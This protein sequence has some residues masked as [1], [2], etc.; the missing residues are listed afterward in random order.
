M[1]F[2]NFKVLGAFALIGAVVATSQVA[3]AQFRFGGR[4][5]PAVSR[6]TRQ[7]PSRSSVRPTR[8]LQRYGIGGTNVPRGQAPPP[9]APP[10]EQRSF[11]FDKKKIDPPI[12]PK[13]H[14]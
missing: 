4:G 10:S 5:R 2:S 3:S 12:R 7:I 6:S 11:V 14:R 8:T 9:T 1:S 13:S